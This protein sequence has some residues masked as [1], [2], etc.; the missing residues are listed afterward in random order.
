[1]RISSSKSSVSLALL[2]KL[3][4]NSVTFRRR[5]WLALTGIVDGRFVGRGFV[6]P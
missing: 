5:G 2:H 3:V 6:T 4:R 1:L